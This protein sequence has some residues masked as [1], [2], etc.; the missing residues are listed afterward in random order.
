MDLRLWKKETT[1][2]LSWLY[3]DANLY[4][5]RKYDRYVKYFCKN[6]FSNVA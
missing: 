6:N 5:Q 2:F 1:K 4:L 3:K